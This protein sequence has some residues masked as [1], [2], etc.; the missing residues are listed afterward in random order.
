ML[1]SSP[2]RPSGTA[3]PSVFVASQVRTGQRGKHKSRSDIH[4]ICDNLA[5]RSIAFLQFQPLNGQ[6]W[7]LHLQNLLEYA[8]NQ[9]E[10]SKI[11]ADSRIHFVYVVDTFF[12]QSNVSSAIR[13]VCIGKN[14]KGLQTPPSTLQALI[15]IKELHE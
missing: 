12:V 2:V 15:S 7:P 4:W 6:K 5:I 14:E 1:F 10:S 13:V 3:L 9:S 8:S 11:S